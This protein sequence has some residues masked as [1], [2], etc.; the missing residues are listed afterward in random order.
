[1][2]LVYS[3]LEGLVVVVPRGFNRGRIPALLERNRR[4]LEH[5][6]ILIEARRRAFNLQDVKRPRR[7]ELQAIGESW[8]LEYRAAEGERATVIQQAGRLLVFGPLTNEAAL[9][10]GILRWL[11]ARARARLTPWLKRLAF[12]HGFTVAAM[13]IKAQRTRWASCSSA[14]AINLNLKLLFLPPELVQYTL[15]HELCHTREL[16]H[17]PRFWAFVK[18]LDLDYLTKDNQLKDAWRYVPPW[19]E[20]K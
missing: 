5:A 12:E 9:R 13:A 6:A 17:S 1:M 20:A 14:K 15:L 3:P 7:L 19:L 2:R 8:E 18:R 10:A 11:A 4:W 16:N